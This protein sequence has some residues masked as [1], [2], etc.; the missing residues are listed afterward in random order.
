MLVSRIL[1]F[2]LAACLVLITDSAQSQRRSQ[3]NSAPQ[4]TQQPTPNDQR[5]TEQSPAFVKI[6]P[7]PKSAAE[8]TQE[9][10]DRKDKKD[11]DWWLVKWTG[12]VAI[13]TF[14]LAAIAAWQGIQLKRTVDLAREEF[15]STHRPRIR[16][17]RIVLDGA[18]GTLGAGWLSHGD[19]F[20]ISITLVNIG[21]I[22]CTII[23][24][25]YEIRFSRIDDSSV[26]FS[27]S[28]IPF[29]EEPITLN[30]GQGHVIKFNRTASLAYPGE[31]VRIIDQFERER[32][33]MLI[34]GEVIYEDSLKRNRSTGFMRECSGKSQFHRIDDP[35]YEYED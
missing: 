2:V 25:H 5:T 9:A 3:P 32:W 12:A 19:E 4:P 24:G 21:D 11:T 34:V 18:H 31:G 14:V 26:G 29:M 1:V 22:A 28:K 23:D 20:E 10:E 27:G 13:F 15:I 16:V 6:I 7:T 17:R 35:D 33:R 30:L 8:T